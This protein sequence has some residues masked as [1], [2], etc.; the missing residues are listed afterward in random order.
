MHNMN[1]TYSVRFEVFMTVPMK[2]IPED[3]ILHLLCLYQSND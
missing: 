3:G 1:L 2:N